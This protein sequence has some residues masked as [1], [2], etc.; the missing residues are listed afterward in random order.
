[1]TAEM[2]ARAQKLIF[3][4]SPLLLTAI[5]VSGT[6]ATAVLTGKA[7][8][9]ALMSEVHRYYD[10]DDYFI[11]KLGAR[12]T[13]RKYW[14][15]YI[16]AMASGVLTVVAIVGANRIGTRRAASLA[17]AYTLAERGYSEYKDKVVEKIGQGKEQAIRDDLAQDRVNRDAGSKQIIISGTDILSHDAFTGRYFQS[18]MEAL[19]KAENDINRQVLNDG[20]ASLSDFYRLIGLQRTSEADEIGWTTDK[21][22]ELKFSTVLSEDGRP[23]LSFEFSVRPARD[24]YKF[25]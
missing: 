9:D 15:L 12:T 24:Y 1:M 18:N 17:A 11:E 20:Y 25:G 21:S 7:T 13:V 4:N 8:H 3:D 10:A 16:P 23:C 6:A 2:I 19:R 22:L 14:K 5:G